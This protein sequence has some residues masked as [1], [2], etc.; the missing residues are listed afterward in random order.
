[1]RETLRRALSPATVIATVA[2]IL[3]VGGTSYAVTRLPHHSV[4]TAQIKNHAVTTPKLATAAAARIAGLTY[5]HMTAAAPPSTAGVI[6]VSCPP[7]LIA[8]SG[9]VETPHTMDAFLLDS[10]PTQSGGWE[11]SVANTSAAT[12]ESITVYAV[13]AKAEGSQ[14]R[15]GVARGARFQRFPYTLS[16]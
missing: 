16:R 5:T 8:I 10:H 4:G 11:A 15:A 9:G 1:M 2:L 6:P 12:T 3:A 7:G 14:A 13:C